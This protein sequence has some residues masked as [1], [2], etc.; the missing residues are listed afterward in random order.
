MVTSAPGPQRERNL[1][2]AICRVPCEEPLCGALHAVVSLHGYSFLS[3]WGR[4][5]QLGR[6][7]CCGFG[8]S[9]RNINTNWKTCKIKVEMN[10]WM[11][12]CCTPKALYNHVGGF[13][14]ITTSVQHS[15]GWCDGCHRTMV[16]EH[17]PH[18]SYRWRGERV[19]EPIECMR[20]PR[21]S[22]RR[23]G[24]RV[25][26]PIKCMRSPHTSYRWRGERVIEPIECMRSPHTSYRWRGESHRANQVYALTT[27]QL[28][29]ERRESHRANQVNWDY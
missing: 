5:V 28:Q 13:S 22:Y 26:E 14:S 4:F 2:S 19:I 7:S 25:I 27:H 24:E 21:T 17:S 18:T 16:P 9:T 15:L 10:E 3:C 23:R 8:D 29:V 20:S 12:D 11:N 6:C 1:G